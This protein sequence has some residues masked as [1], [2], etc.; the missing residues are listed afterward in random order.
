MRR[1]GLRPRWRTDTRLEPSSREAS[2]VGIACALQSLDARPTARPLLRRTAGVSPGW[3]V[4]EASN[5]GP[6]RQSARELAHSGRDLAE[7][8]TA[9][10][11]RRRRYL[12]DAM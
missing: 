8:G 12:P 1:S 10:R 5:L 9:T 7:G 11:I 6:V 4:R 2:V 3:P